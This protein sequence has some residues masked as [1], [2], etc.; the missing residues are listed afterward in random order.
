[1]EE[2]RLPKGYIILHG[3]QSGNEFVVNTN[4]I[5]KLLTRA[6]ANRN[7]FTAIYINGCNRTE[8]GVTYP[9]V[10]VRETVSEVLELIKTSQTF[11]I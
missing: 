2:Q 11:T 7:A 9:S 1:M 3:Y 10:E 6:D 4:L 8:N 5:G